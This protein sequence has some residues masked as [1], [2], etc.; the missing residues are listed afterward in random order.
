MKL[1]LPVLLL[2]VSFKSIAQITITTQP[3]TSTQTI[4]VGATANALSVTATGSGLSYQWYSNTVKNNSGGSIV[5]RATSS[6]Y[7]PASDVA[8]TKYYYVVVSSTNGSSATSNVS[9]AVTINALPS[10]SYTVTP[11]VLCSGTPVQFNATSVCGSNSA[12]N[13]SGANS[14]ALRSTI[15]TQVDNITM[16]AW[17]NWSGGKNGQS[18]DQEIFYNGHTGNGGYGILMTAGGNLK[19]LIG[20]LAYLGSSQNLK[21]GVWTHVAIVR[22][23]GTWALYVN[24]TYNDVSPNTTTPNSPTVAGGNQTMVGADQSGTGH[25]FYGSIDEVK[26]WSIARSASDIQADMI[27]CSVN[28]QSG[29]LGYWNFNDGSGS[30]AADGSG[31]GYALTLT[32]TSWVTTSAPTGATFAWNFDGSTSNLPADATTFATSSVKNISLTVTDAT[33]GCVATS[34]GTVSVNMSPTVSITGT[35]TACDTVRLTASG[36]GSYLWNG[37]TS[38]N[39]ASNSFTAS[40]TYTVVVTDAIGCASSASQ[41]VTVNAP[42][43]SPISGPIGTTSTF[44]S[45]GVS[46]PYAI[47]KDASGNL[48]VANFSANTISKITPSGTV[49]T[50]VS[51]GLSRP[52][53]LAFDASG[54]LYVANY[55]ANTI[56]RVTT[57]GVVSSFVSTGLSSPAG[58]AFDAS[59]NLY[60]A[61]Y[62][63]GTIS[64]VTTSRVVSTYVSSGLSSPAGLAFDAS[65]NLYVANYSNSTVSKITT[66]RVVSTF[67][68]SGLSNPVGLAFDDAGSLYI[69]NYG[70]NIVNKVSSSGGTPTS[71]AITGLNRPRGMLFDATNKL[72]YVVNYSGSNVAKITPP[73][74]YVTALCNVGSFALIA[75]PNSGQVIDWYDAATAGNLLQASSSTYQTPSITT[76]TTYYAEARNAT[77]GC[78]SVTRTAIVAV[79]NT[80]NNTWNGSTNN[81][82]N[83]PL[84]W[85]GNNVP[86][87]TANLTIASSANNPQITGTTVVNNLEIQSGASVTVTGTLKIAGSINNSG[88]I[89]AT[90]GTIELNGAT[91]QTIPAATFTGDTVRNL[92]INNTSGVI[93][94]GN[95]LLTGLL[96]P[97][98]GVLTTNGRL[99]LVSTDINGGGAIAQGSSTGGYISGSVT[100][101]RY[102]QAQRGYR[103]LAHPYNTGQPLSLLTNT[104]AITG[105]DTA[106]GNY[107]KT[108]ATGGPSVFYYNPLK[109]AGSASVLE[110]ITN[111]T[112]TNKWLVGGGIYLFVRGNGN[113]GLGGPGSSNYVAG[114]ISPVTF[115]VA[116]GNINQGAVNVSLV[117]G[118]ASTDNYNLIGNPYACPINLKNVTG[119]PYGTIYVYNPTKNIALGNPYIM[120][121]GFDTY[122]HNGSNDIII[123][124][125]G[126]F[127][128]QTTAAGQ[129]ITFNET[130]KI[131]NTTPTYA[132]FGTSKNAALQLAIKNDKGVIDELKFAF[133]ASATADANDLYDATKKGNSLLDFYSISNDKKYLAI[134]YRSDKALSN[135]LP[136]G[137]KTNLTG[138]FYLQPTAIVDLPQ[139]QLVLRDKLLQKETILQ[140]DST[141]G[142]AFTIT[143]DTATKGNNRFEIGLLAT[144]VLPATIG[145][146]YADVLSAN[147]VSIKWNS[148]VELNTDHY[149]VQRSIDGINFKEVATVVAKGA[150][151]YDYVDNLPASLLATLTNATIY[152]RLQIVDKNGST[153]YSKVVAVT[154]NNAVSSKIHLYPNPVTNYVFVQI[155]SNKTEQVTLSVIDNQGK[156]L[157]QK[158]GTLNVGLTTLPLKVTTLAT[159]IYH[160]KISTANITQQLIFIK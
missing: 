125:M 93:L 108:S 136:L 53:A 11:S 120:S 47:A 74:A 134:D 106:N 122:T 54:N 70:N 121:G 86:S 66:S 132:T 118:D 39:T 52:A 111:P 26:F 88:T 113:E 117:Y 19:I 16:E 107:G 2:F 115:S 147:A 98:N 159:G 40:S 119:L 95:V 55:S 109:P 133:N 30:V 18:D 41:A 37:G 99:T 137:I 82:F 143:T 131:T 65:G 148:L 31:N 48:Y 38:V 139:T 128:L 90:N 61:N 36:G 8:G 75:T 1:I 156:I 112:A 60:V 94:G 105:L 29:L 124:T 100:V 84:N 22:N 135:F 45:S 151:D 150:S 73:S 89:N 83:N 116:N 49:S 92:T 7:T 20:G 76:S 152:Y 155:P 157:L 97:T 50:F 79:V 42:P 12:L 130:D 44:V 127:Y 14:S 64:R 140:A 145:N 62:S 21:P 13:F 154:F 69:S 24:G 72:F 85:N 104:I 141:N 81:D 129:S 77:T 59:G 146:I 80:C 3:S 126:C 153:S 110:A 4:C 33:T 101:Q 63:N 51:S 103:T 15:T 23:N 138:N 28:A 58:L 17:V 34:S 114:T 71:F 67:V 158:E 142:Y 32:N 27:A 35:A 160:L 68:S 10:S 9:G 102:T 57:G 87:A 149:L 25:L 43:T 5:S 144:T 46:L 78:V 6:F 91:A 96:Q 123:P 56:S